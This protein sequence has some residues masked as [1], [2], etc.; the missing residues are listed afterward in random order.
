MFISVS[1]QTTLLNEDNFFVFA[2]YDST[3]PT[4]LLEKQVPTKP[5][6]N[7]L[8]ISFTYNCLDGHIYNIKL[9]ESPDD[10]PTGVVRN[11]FSQA[12]NS[13][14]LAVR[15]PEYLQADITAGLVNGAT[16]Y[17]DTSWAGWNYWIVRNPN[18]MIPDYTDNDNPDYHQDAT[19]GF[20]LIQSGDTFQPNEKFEVYFV[21]QITA[22]AGGDPSPIFST[23]RIITANETLTSGDVGK[24]LLIQSATNKIT[25]TLPSLASVSD[26]AFLY[27]YSCGGSHINA[28]FALP[29]TDKILYNGA[30]RSQL[31]LGQ[32]EALK[33]YKAFGKWNVDGDLTGVKQVG[34]LLYNY[35][36]NEINT[37]PC[38]GAVLQRNQYPR[39]WE[40]AQQLAAGLI[41]SESA[42]FSTFIT[43]DGINYFTKR[44]YF[45][46]G[47]GSTT[48][49]VP[50]IINYFIRPVDG[51]ARI[52]GSFE[53]QTI[54][55]HTH[56]LTP[57][58]SQGPP[59]YG[60]ITTGNEADEPVQP[61]FTTDSTG[62]TET[63]PSNIGSY[64]LMRT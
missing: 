23:G 50:S 24:A 44:G 62:D 46:S 25:I 54:Q 8:Q 61:V 27:V 5:Y 33:C 42:W 63:K 29:G 30:N 57:P 18:T 53:L 14:S 38:N 58:T 48:F 6:G 59:G 39:L 21:P 4:V 7:P 9:W 56:T 1:S 17:V 60:K 32:S 40:W 10:T 15:L 37:I 2:L 16:S 64:V 22:G 43:V 28:V 34:E 19:G 49:R 36:L 52:P 11:S 45:S 55:A 51:T 3:A 13:F 26:F 41:V 31:I 47:D 12:V 35:A 20:S